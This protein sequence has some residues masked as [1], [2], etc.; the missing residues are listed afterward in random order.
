RSPRFRRSAHKYSLFF[1]LSTPPQRIVLR[2]FRHVVHLR[3]SNAGSCCCLRCSRRVPHQGPRD[4]PQRSA[5][6]SRS[7]GGKDRSTTLQRWRRGAR[8]H[9][10]IALCSCLLLRH[11]GVHSGREVQ[12]QQ[13][14]RPSDSRCSG[15]PRLSEDTPRQ[16]PRRPRVCL[17]SRHGSVDGSHRRL[18]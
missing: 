3:S 2:L 5:P 10:D 14:P 4:H 8:S 9:R 18:G 17:P 15:I 16:L 13:H 7:R 11:V 12:A 6:H 1:E